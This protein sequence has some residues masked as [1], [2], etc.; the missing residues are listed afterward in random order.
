MICVHGYNRHFPE[1]W[2]F[3][4]GLGA[5]V[6]CSHLEIPRIGNKISEGLGMGKYKACKGNSNSDESS[7]PGV[8]GTGAAAQKGLHRG[9]VTVGAKQALCDRFFARAS[10]SSIIYFPPKS[11]W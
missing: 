6:R 4:M 9:S 11:V 1:D 3:E 10:H 7:V 8:I 2:A 5:R